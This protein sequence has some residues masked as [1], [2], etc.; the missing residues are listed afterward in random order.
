MNLHPIEPYILDELNQPQDKE[1]TMRGL[2]ILRD[3]K[4]PTP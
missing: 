3:M 2:K 4:L 1:T